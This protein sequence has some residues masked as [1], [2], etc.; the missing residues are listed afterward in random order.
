M[1]SLELSRHVLDQIQNKLKIAARL[2][3]ADGYSGWR[4]K[5]I[6]SNLYTAYILLRVY[7]K[8]VVDT[9]KD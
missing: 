4:Y 2:T 7:R 1:R 9:V 6:G 5:G 8:V 3:L